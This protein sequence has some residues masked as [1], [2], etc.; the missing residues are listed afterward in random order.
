MSYRHTT[1]SPH[2][3]YALLGVVVLSSIAS[4]I[5]LPASHNGVVDV[6]GT[7]RAQSVFREK[8]SANKTLLA[9][10]FSCKGNVAR[11]F[12]GPTFIGHCYKL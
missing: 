2:Y 7:R 1:D 8:Y 6:R 4:A 10:S 12:L 9:E 11:V 3:S 5:P